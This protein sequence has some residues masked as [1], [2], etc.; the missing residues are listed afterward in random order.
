[1]T[2]AP[3]HQPLAQP[4]GAEPTAKPMQGRLTASDLEIL[5]EKL[6][7][8]IKRELQFDNDREGRPS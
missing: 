4:A 6:I 2:L 8:M 5:A 3:I 7:E 1:M